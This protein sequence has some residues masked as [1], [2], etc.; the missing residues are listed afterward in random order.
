MGQGVGRWRVGGGGRG[1][2]AFLFKPKGETLFLNK[3]NLLLIV[4]ECI[5]IIP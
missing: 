5:L 2:G 1:G 4:F 3:N